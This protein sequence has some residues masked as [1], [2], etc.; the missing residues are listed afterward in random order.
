VYD[1]ALCVADVREEAVQLEP[2]YKALAGFE[3]AFD[4]ET[5]DRTE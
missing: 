4:A 2:V 3:A 5:E 1:Q